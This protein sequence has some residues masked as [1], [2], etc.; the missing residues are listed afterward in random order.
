MR[1]TLI[2]IVLLVLLGGIAGNAGAQVLGTNWEAVFYNNATFSGE[3]IATVEYPFGLNFNWGNGGPRDND[4]ELIPG[5]NADNFSARFTSTQT[6]ASPGTY[7]FRV[8]AND[9]VR[10]TINGEIVLDRLNLV[11]QDGSYA[12]FEFQRTLEAGEV[13]MLVEYVEYLGN[14]L[15]QVQWGFAFNGVTEFSE[16]FEEE[17]GQPGVPPGWKLDKRNGDKRVCNDDAATPPIVV[18]YSGSC[19]FR[20]RGGKGEAALLAYNQPMTDNSRDFLV[21]FQLYLNAPDPAA[22]GV[23]RV[24]VVRPNGTQVVVA[25]IPIRQ[26]TGYQQFT[27]QVSVLGRIRTARIEIRHTSPA[28]QV[29][30]DELSLKLDGPAALGSAQRVPLA[31][32]R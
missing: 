15:L 3:V 2:G 26:T 19:A 1:R 6:F 28:G 25:K 20:F 31:L 17:G 16:D 7:T 29:L 27:R 5:F 21:S 11:V 9:S 22:R 32:A 23:A 8:L 18:A 30:I 12:T 10:M 4:G 13:E 14:A 24:V